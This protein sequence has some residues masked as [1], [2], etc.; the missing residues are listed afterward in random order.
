MADIVALGVMDACYR[1]SVPVPETLS[2]A[3]FDDI[4]DA[5]LARPALTTL[6]QPAAGK[7]LEATR[8]LLSLLDG[9]A[10]QHKNLDTDLVIRESTAPASRRV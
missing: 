5:A 3:G 6:R 1:L 2:V 7:G 10:A 4:P 8:L 9:S